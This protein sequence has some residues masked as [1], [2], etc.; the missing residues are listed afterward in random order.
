MLFSIF[1]KD[2]GEEDNKAP[3]IKVGNKL[4]LGV[5]EQDIFGK[6]SYKESVKEEK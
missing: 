6:K 4:S 1:G 3:A 2:S 5:D